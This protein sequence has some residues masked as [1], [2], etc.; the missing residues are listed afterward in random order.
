MYFLRILSRVHFKRS[1]EKL[2]VGRKDSVWVCSA[3]FCY[4]LE[5]RWPNH[6]YAYTT[7]FNREKLLEIRM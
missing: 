5:A 2:A 3:I 1:K 7:R 4:A 6:P